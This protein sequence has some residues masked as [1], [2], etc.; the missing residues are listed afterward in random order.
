MGGAGGWP[1]GGGAARS[2]KS[3]AFWALYSQTRVLCRPAVGTLEDRT[4]TLA[5]YA[6]G[7]LALNTRIGATR[8][9]WARPSGGT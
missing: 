6:T 8:E 1:V 3:G 5:V 9:A 7:R 4:R 2:N